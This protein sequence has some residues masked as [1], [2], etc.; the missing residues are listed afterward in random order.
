[1]STT[2][3]SDS[4]LPKMPAMKHRIATYFDCRG[5]DPRFL[6][7]FAF[8]LAFSPGAVRAD[9]S[10]GLWVG[11]AILGQVNEVVSAVN[12]DQV[13]VQTPPQTTTPTSDH[14]EIQLILHVDGDGHVRL[15]KSVAIADDDDDPQ[16]VEERLITD[17]AL[18][19]NYTLARRIAAAAFDFGDRDARAVVESVATAAATAVLQGLDPLE[20]ANAAVQAAEG[21]SHAAALETFIGS[22][23]F[24]GSAAT[25]AAA[26]AAALLEKS[27][28]GLGGQDLDDAVNSEVLI[29]LG[30]VLQM[31]DGVSLNEAPMAGALTKGGVVEG[32]IFLG[33]YHPTNPFRHRKNPAHRGG[34]DIERHL[35]LTVSDPDGG[36]DF[37]TTERGVDR[38]TGIYEEEIFGLH[39]PL[40]QNGEYGLR[41]KGAFV[42]D[43]ISRDATLND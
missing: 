16:G 17:P 10:E 25:A 35:T 26:A 15:L 23:A 40:G 22:A 33:A 7:A 6:L 20:A 8:A 18:F 43:R 37:D 28:E 34:Y 13:R 14:A 12:A 31:A 21:G 32:D 30:T 24:T 29:A 27:A 9:L 3:S 1:M 39:K 11:R 4:S 2:F 42:L 5:L 41:T 38:L 36:A 19:P